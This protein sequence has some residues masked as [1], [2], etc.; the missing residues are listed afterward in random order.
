MVTLE[1]NGTK[2]K[3]RKLQDWPLSPGDTFID[4]F[5]HT[6]VLIL[7]NGKALNLLGGFA[8]DAC[9]FTEEFIPCDFTLNY[10]V[11]E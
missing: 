1:S 10:E 2:Y 7:A 4:S 9:Y 11:Q 6:P 5:R 8:T 3:A